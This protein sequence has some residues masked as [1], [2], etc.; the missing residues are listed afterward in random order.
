MPCPA[1]ILGYL[2]TICLAHSGASRGVRELAPA[3]R[4]SGLPGRAP[5]INLEARQLPRSALLLYSGGSLS[6]SD[7]TTLVP[8]K[9]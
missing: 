3:V 5:R 4:R 8:L 9:W 1:N 6:F 2:S 7:P